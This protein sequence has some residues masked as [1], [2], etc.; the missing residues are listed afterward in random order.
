MTVD[1]GWDN[2]YFAS[3]AILIIIFTLIALFHFCL[4]LTCLL[5]LE[6]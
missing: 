6:A 5:L 4:P 3:G 2:I 1:E